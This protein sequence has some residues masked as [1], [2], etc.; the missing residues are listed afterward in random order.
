MNNEYQPSGL[1]QVVHYNFVEGHLLVDGEPLGRLPLDV[2]ESPDVRDLFGDQHLLTFPSPLAGMDQVL[3]TPV[4][5][6]EVHFGRR[7]DEVVIRALRCEPI[8]LRTWTLLE[9]VPSRVFWNNSEFDLPAELIDGCTHWLDLKSGDLEIRR[10]PAI[11]TSRPGNWI[12]NVHNRMAK[13]RDST[14]V[15][16]HSEI[17][18]KINGILQG[19]ERPERMTVYQPRKFKLSVELKQLELSFFVNSNKLLECRQLRAEID[20]NQDAGTLYGLES[21]LVVRNM[22]DRSRRSLIVALGELSYQRRGIHVLVK[23]RDSHGYGK[24]EI[25]SV[26][27]R[28][29]CPPETRLLYFMALL[30]ASTSFPIPDPLTSSTGAEEAFCILGS[31][32]CQPWMPLTQHNILVQVQRLCP[33]RS[34]YPSDKRLVQKVEWNSNLTTEIQQ[35]FYGRLIKGL[36]DKSER[37]KT[38]YEQET[39]ASP[40][41]RESVSYLRER[42]ILRRAVHQRSGAERSQLVGHNE[43]VAVYQPRD[44]MA[45]SIQAKRVYQATKLLFRQP[46]TVNLPK[47]HLVQLIENLGGDLIGGFLGTPDG[48]YASLDLSINI[49]IVEQLGAVVNFCRNVENHTIFDAVFRLGLLAFSSHADMELVGLLCAFARLHELKALVPP[50]C[51]WFVDFANRTQ[52]SLS[53]IEELIL[54]DLLEESKPL[55]GIFQRQG[56]ILD[57]GEGARLK[58]L[59]KSMSKYLF[60]QWPCAEPST[61]AFRVEPSLQAVAM[62]LTARPLEELKQEWMQMYNNLQLAEYLNKVQSVLNYYVGAQEISGPKPWCPASDTFCWP[63]RDAVVPSLSREL[64]LKEAF[65]PALESSHRIALPMSNDVSLGAACFDKA[66]NSRG[67]RELDQVLKTFIGSHKPLWQ[68]YGQ[69]LKESYDALRQLPAP[70]Q[71]H[72]H[73]PNLGDIDQNIVSVQETISK[74]FSIISSALSSNDDRF[75]WLSLGNLWPRISPVSLLEQL[76]SKDSVKFGIDMKEILISYGI[77]ITMYQWLLRV[78]QAHLGG[79]WEK[80]NEHLTENGHAN[81]NPM[82]FPDWL[83]L[84]IES[85]MLIRREQ[86]EVAKEIISPASPVNS[87]LQ[88]N[89]GKGGQNVMYR[90]YGCGSPGRLK[91]ALSSNRTKG[92]ATT[93]GADTASKDRWTTRT[94]DEACALCQTHLVDKPCSKTL[95][96]LHQDIL[97]HSGLILAIPENILSYKLSGLQQLADSH[98]NIAREML[99][100]QSWLSRMSR[101][102]LDESDF[103]LAVKTQLIYPSGQLVP[104]DGHPERWRVAQ[105]LLSLIRDNLTYVSKRYPGGLEVVSRNPGFPMVY[106]VQREVEDALLQRVIDTVCDGHTSILRLPSATTTACRQH[107]KRIMTEQSPDPQIFASLA[108]D[109][110]ETPS[111]LNNALIVRG[112]LLKRI[113]FLCLRKRWNVQYGLHPSRNPLAVPFEAKGVPSEHAEFGHPDVAIVFTCLSFYYAGLTIDQFRHDLGSV[114]KADDPAIEYDA[115]TSGCTSLPEA[116][117]HWNLINIDDSGQV[118]ELWKHLRLSRGVLDHYLNSFV[119]PRYAK[120]FAVKLQSSAW[121]LPLFSPDDR[122]PRAR[123]TGFSGTN[124]NRRLLPLTI[125]QN[126]LASLKHTSAEVLACLLQ[127]RNRPCMIAVRGTT[128]LTE[129]QL[130]GRL[131]ERNIRLLIDAGAYVLEMDNHSLIQRWLGQDKEAKAGVYFGS[132]NRAWVQYRDGKTPIPLLA[133]P[134]ADNLT[135]CVVYLDEAHTRGTVSGA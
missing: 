96:E 100:V 113:L 133:T 115:W 122:V 91:E 99:Q 112:L 41:E 104:V 123:T 1:P 40:Y 54:V 65:A 7:G 56:T 106:V 48:Q 80:L 15:D 131:E 51:P 120:Q 19:L 90:T 101:D 66:V 4:Y 36:V 126:D 20:P 30:H 95:P 83:L 45:E 92:F 97:F 129:E 3:A 50:D 71:G 111:L 6:Y 93:N 8:R 35:D 114:L 132:D 47:V 79:D 55:R 34:F 76:R 9:Y 46:F 57:T 127:E 108:R 53:R 31:G 11:W 58:R 103:T 17:C 75:P 98:V 119:F 21:M 94:R 121:D 72:I 14:L 118:E 88:L 24:L 10:K 86:V 128:R 22:V 77:S 74:T 70:R 125:K 78:K 130:L 42:A 81:W 25:D 110:A 89:M 64:L 85:S 63:T 29:I 37:L 16:P 67:M 134:F 109:W 27:G 13:R 116:L 61:D 135:E 23:V 5:G 52:L 62:D 84:E 68:Q 87:V 107:V 12:L 60:V 102:V 49:E 2:I 43:W 69:D 33:V 117:A 73:P 26:L 28:L 59:T 39:I 32:S 44:R 82:D 105:E 18:H 38:F 124:D